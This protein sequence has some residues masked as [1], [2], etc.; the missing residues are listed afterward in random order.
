[1]ELS[2]FAKTLLI[3]LNAIGCCFR[4]DCDWASHLSTSSQSATIQENIFHFLFT[5]LFP[6]YR[7]EKSVHFARKTRLIPFARRQRRVVN[8]AVLMADIVLTT[9]NAK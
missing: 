9:L 1:M 6:G 7:H 2:T 4:H 8:S 5:D 3:E